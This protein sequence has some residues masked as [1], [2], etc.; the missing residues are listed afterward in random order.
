[1][2][3]ASQDGKPDPKTLTTRDQFRAALRAVKG[4]LIFAAV[5]ARSEQLVAEVNESG[6]KL[7]YAPMPLDDSTLSEWMSE[8][9]KR[10]TLPSPDRLRTYLAVCGVPDA[11]V[12]HWLAALHRV[13]ASVEAM[14][15]G[16]VA[17][18]PSSAPQSPAYPLV[19]H[20]KPSRRRWLA[21]GV[22]ALL[23]ALGTF[24][25]VDSPTFTNAGTGPPTKPADSDTTIAGPTVPT[26][27]IFDDFNG[28]LDLA[29]KW[30]LN[31]PEAQTRHQVYVSGG[32]LHLQ[33]TTDN[34][35]SGVDATLTPILPPARAIMAVSFTMTLVSQDGRSD[36]AAYLIVSSQRGREH[37]LWMG[38]DGDKQPAVG[39]Y[40]CSRD[41]CADRDQY[42]HSQGKLEKGRAYTVNVTN[43]G[44]VKFD[45]SG[46]P[47]V[48]AP[49][50][51]VPLDGFRF[52]LSSDA[53]RN[54][55]V[56]IDDLRIT[57]AFGTKCVVD[58]AYAVGLNHV[59]RQNGQDGIGSQ[60]NVDVKVN[61][62]PAA[63]HNYWL[64][65]KVTDGPAVYVAKY[66]L[67]PTVGPQQ[68]QMSL[69]LSGR[70]ATRDIFVVDGDPS[71][72]IWL[73]QNK[74]AEN[75]HSQKPESARQKL[76]DGVAA[77]SNVCSIKKTVDG[78]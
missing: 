54:F 76:A 43:V 73:Q 48:I 37:R 70:N 23:V 22:V 38:P 28:D 74:A 39:Y 24:V 46:Y 30:S 52:Y 21:V 5:R 11:D 65:S 50:D 78:P 15:V 59:S 2:G 31:V 7:D 41:A 42:D 8:S 58:R 1:M 64:I 75:D 62:P 36:G 44:G 49:A 9:S 77:V 55:H 13:R 18:T 20:P 57:Y 26:A 53:G 29:H 51:D 27:E 47:P 17:T 68:A 3:D 67:V 25:L 34:S 45:V 35:A 33:V 69:P 6:R 60:L 71:G 72:S 56:S 16:D 66:H 63:G 4:K 61:K 19:Q 12:V 14:S 10:T 32:K 40:I